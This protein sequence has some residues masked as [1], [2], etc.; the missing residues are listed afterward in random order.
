MELDPDP[1]NITGKL[2]LL[3]ILT[4]VNAFFAAAEMAIVSI[5]KTKMKML[6]NEGNKKANI[7]CKLVEEPTKFLST[8]QVAI[9]LSGF[10]A[11]A[12]AATGISTVVGKRLTE[13]NIP[14][15][16]QISFVGITVI[17]SYFTLVFGELFPKR[18]AIKKADKLSMIVVKP[19]IF[20]SK[21]ASPFV[22]ILS[23]S[24]N[25]L[26]KLFGLDSEDSEEKIT[27]EEIKSIVET[28]EEHGAL[29]ENEKDMIEG[30]FDFEDKIAEKVMTP[31]TEVYCIDINEPIEEYLDEFLQKRFARVP[32]YDDDIDNIIG[33][34]YMK[35]F[36]IEARDKGFENVN[37]KDILQE[38][39]F[40]PECK[41]IKHLF[42]DLQD[43]KRHI[44]IIVDE[45]GGFSGIITIEDLVEEI[46][47]EINDE[48][49]EE[50]FGIRQVSEKCYLVDGTTQLEELNDN[51]NIDVKSDDVDTLNGF[52]INLIGR[53][54]LDEEDKEIKYNN[55]TFKID[56]V[57]EKKIEKVRICI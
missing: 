34:L 29:N 1:A 45:Y 51:L 4:A 12:S 32:V 31:R 30:V 37:I 42:K 16:E 38:A 10:F 8:I 44:A 27:K 7:I 41:P 9:T 25:L 49:D 3:V 11:S 40:V 24:T 55:V 6:A 22:K 21:I 54:P 28:G 53:I 43:F 20:V 13:M 50:S 33:V 5:N 23:V 56:E 15:G 46:V 26:V 14:Y 17:L 18:L 19:I 36:I 57:S 52:L 35:D 2:I 39:Y 47:G 48:D